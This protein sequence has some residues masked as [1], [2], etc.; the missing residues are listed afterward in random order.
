MYFLSG[1][2]RLSRRSGLLLTSIIGCR[3]KSPRNLECMVA[4]D[5]NDVERMLAGQQSTAQITSLE[6]YLQDV[7]DAIDPSHSMA[8]TEQHRK[9]MIRCLLGYKNKA[10][11]DLRLQNIDISLQ[12]EK[13]D[14]FVRHNLTGLNPPET[15]APMFQDGLRLQQKSDPQFS[16]QRLDAQNQTKYMAPS[17]FFSF[18]SPGRAYPGR[19]EKLLDDVA[20]NFL[21]TYQDIIENRSEIELMRML[22]LNEIGVGVEAS[23]NTTITHHEKPDVSSRRAVIWKEQLLQL[24]AK[25]FGSKGNQ[26]PEDGGNFIGKKVEGD[27][28]SYL[29]QLSEDTPNNATMVI[30]N[31]LVKS[32]KRHI[33]QINQCNGPNKWLPHVILSNANLV[34]MTSEFDSMVVEMRGSKIRIVELWEAKASL[35]PVT[36]SDALFKKLHALNTVLQDPDAQICFFPKNNPQVSE[37]LSTGSNLDYDA[38]LKDDE[39]VIFPL[40]CHGDSAG[41][42]NEGNA[43]DGVYDSLRP[44]LG[45]FGM[46]LM[47]PDAAARRAQFV[48]CE[49]RLERSTDA[50]LE[51]LETGFVSAPD[52]RPDLERM[53]KAAQRLKPMLVVPLS[54]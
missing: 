21:E 11:F 48:H 36:I 25:D 28:V 49:T 35:N 10:E 29:E 37:F 51:G 15:K 5:P 52:I 22:V 42:N 9:K 43:D 34:G 12:W 41:E 26:P 1:L 7:I 18:L 20:P 27:L 31:V 40:V 46:D 2:M 13:T 33:R 39:P 30:S 19:F 17:R 8:I 23:C 6:Q 4:T 47:S 24:L 3:W 38:L 44:R 14:R 53:L 50:V 32:P 45:I 54:D 16:F